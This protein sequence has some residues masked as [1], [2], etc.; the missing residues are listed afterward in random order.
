MDYRGIERS[1]TDIALAISGKGKYGLTTPDLSWH[2]IGAA[3]EPAFQNSWV[4]YGS[5]YNICAFRKDAMGFVHL[6]GLAKSGTAT[7]DLPFF[8]LPVGYRPS[9]VSMFAVVSN[10]ALGQVRVKPDGQVVF[11]TGSNAWVS[12][13]GITFK[14]E[15]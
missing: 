6:E 4:N 10:N 9:M 15:N 3:D 8:T 14:A 2:E 12:F 1:L 13:D 5:V 7:Y 11:Y